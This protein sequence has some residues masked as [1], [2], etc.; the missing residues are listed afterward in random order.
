[1][2]RL[3]FDKE[4]LTSPENLLD[5]KSRCTSSEQ[6]ENDGKMVEKLFKERSKWE[7]FGQLKAGKSPETLL[8][9]KEK[10]LSCAQVLDNKY[11]TTFG[12]EIL[13]NE[14]SRSCKVRPCVPLESLT[15]ENSNKFRDRLR[16]L[17]L[18]HTRKLLRS[19]SWP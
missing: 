4:V 11:G 2:R 3:Q 13:L 1:M 7:R 8:P 9:F 18:W 17:K 15:G 12:P 14:R 19:E 10:K 5:E 16:E 6:S